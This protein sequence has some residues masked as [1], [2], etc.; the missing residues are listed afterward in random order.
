MLGFCGTVKRLRQELCLEF[1]FA[2]HLHRESRQA[3]SY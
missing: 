2:P 3:L 1:Q